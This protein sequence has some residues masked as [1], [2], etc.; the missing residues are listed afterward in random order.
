MYPPNLEMERLGPKL[1]HPCLP[2]LSCIGPCISTLLPKMTSRFRRV[3]AAPSGQAPRLDLAEDRRSCWHHIQHHWRKKLVSAFTISLKRFPWKHCP[4]K[5][6]LCK[7][8]PWKSF[9]WKSFPWKGYPWKG[10]PWKLLT[11]FVRR[12]NTAAGSLAPE[13][14]S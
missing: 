3:P 8:L 1:T 9:P 13:T 10:F 4:C 7:S 2:L 6:F 11:H 12:S 14:P 5:K